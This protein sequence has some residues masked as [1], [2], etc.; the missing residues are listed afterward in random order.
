MPVT[1]EQLQERT[2]RPLLAVLA[3]IH[4]DGSPQAT[5]MWYDYDGKYFYCNTNPRR[6]K[7]KNIRRDPRV[8]LCIVDTP[9]HPVAPVIVRG[10]A[11]L[12]EE[13]D[14]ET[15]RRLAYRYA[16]PE[17]GEQMMRDGFSKEKRVTI[18]ITPEK[19]L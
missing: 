13:G 4:K 14:Q 3:T 11:E 18:R 17:R 7:A 6:V 2:S 19:I 1:P 5:P 12:I 16:G 10:R 9:H 15:I 8:T